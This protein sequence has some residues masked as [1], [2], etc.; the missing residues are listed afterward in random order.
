[1]IKIKLLWQDYNFFPYEKIL[2]QLEVEK[3]FNSVPIETSEGLEI[4][5]GAGSL[6]ALKRVTYFKAVIVNDEKVIIPDQVKFELSYNGNGNQKVSKAKNSLPRISRQVTRYSAHGIHDYRGKFNPQ[7]VRAIANLFA[8]EK[9][10]WLFDP[11]CGSGTTLLEAAHLGFNAIGTDL[12]PLSV[13]ISNAKLRVIKSSATTL[14]KVSKELCAKLMEV[15]NQKC[16]W[17]KELPEHDYL[18]KWFP[19]EVLRK[20][21]VLFKE[22][23]ALGILRL[24]PFLFVLLSDLVREASFQD[25]DD[26][27]IRR[28]KDII[29]DF[30]LFERYCS[31]LFKRTEAVLSAKASVNIDRRYFQK[32]LL[33]DSRVIRDYRKYVYK[34]HFNSFDFAITSPPY[35][36][37][38]PYLD[39]QRLSLVLLSMIEPKRLQKA[40]K[41]LIGSREVSKAERVALEN[42]LMSNDSALPENVIVFCRQLLKLSIHEDHGFRKKNVPALVYKYLSEMK[43]S[44]SSTHHLLRR[45]GKFGLVVGQNKTNLQDND[46]VINTPELLASIAEEIGWVVDD[47]II[48]NTYQR[49]DLHKDNSIKEEKLLILKKR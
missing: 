26:L 27:R 23:E 6:E 36:T 30:P 1:M 22:I 20:L 24:K 42:A 2:G 41:E 17:Q 45:G 48:L 14:K 32:A 39:T 37:A 44:L 12:N 49:Y 10:D 31:D 47:I 33:A 3:L 19:E 29:D 7:I 8:V 25:P 13:E 35:A 5:C 15:R 38:L 46:I 16:K 11:F 43:K 34:R 18:E 28:R 4:Q 21:C 9:G 40:E